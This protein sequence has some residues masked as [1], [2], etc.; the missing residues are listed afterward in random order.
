MQEIDAA[1]EKI[2]RDRILDIVQTQPKQYQATLYAIFKEA[3]NNSVLTGE[4]YERYKDICDQTGLRPLTQRRVSDILA[5]LDMLGLIT[6]KVIS[7]GRFGRTREISLSIPS[8]LESRAK[9]M[10]EEDLGLQ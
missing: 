4:V 6:A 2:E 1:Q 7:K 5:E 8:S 3:S 9:A 10:V